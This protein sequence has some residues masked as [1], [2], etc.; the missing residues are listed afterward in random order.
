M[1]NRVTEVAA[2]ALLTEVVAI[3]LETF[4]R[5]RSLLPITVYGE[6][7]N[8]LLPSNSPSPGV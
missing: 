5:S 8:P 7:E 2:H 3:M 4:P 6:T 1:A